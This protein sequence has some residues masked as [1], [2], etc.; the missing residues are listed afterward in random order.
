M[1]EGLGSLTNL[2]FLWIVHQVPLILPTSLAPTL[3]GVHTMSKG[4]CT[5]NFSSCGGHFEETG[6][7]RH[8]HWSRGEGQRAL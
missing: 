5:A 6:W 8:L 7:E 4:A 3:R 1:P 2:E